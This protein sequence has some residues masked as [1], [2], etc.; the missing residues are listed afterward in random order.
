M[1]TSFGE[2]A[3]RHWEDAEILAERRRVHNAD[4]LYGLAAE[5]ALKR[6]MIT[7]GVPA[8]SDGDIDRKYKIHIDKL[9]EEYRTLASGRRGARYLSPLSRFPDNPFADWHIEQRYAP[10]E[11][12]PAGSVC[13]AH[14]RAARACLDALRRIQ[15]DES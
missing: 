3:R 9:W 1:G 5:C 12:P 4:Q 14:K 11:P 13:Q 6:V 7:L 8:S 10:A 15:E 2:A